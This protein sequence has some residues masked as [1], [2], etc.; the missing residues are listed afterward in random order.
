MAGKLSVYTSNFVL[1]KILR[2]TDWTPPSS[3]WV[4]L[5]LAGSETALRNNTVT[6]G[7]E[8]PNSNAYARQEIRGA[9]SIT[10]PA[11]TAGS[12]SNSA[13]IVFPTATGS[14]G[15][16]YYVALLDSSTI[17]AGNVILY[18][19]LSTAKPVDSGDTM[20]INT[21]SMVLSL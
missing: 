21:G 11:S 10:F 16:I 9:T 13:A 4:G 7:I 6:S 15:T 5:F 12:T 1:N 20:R 17:G 14:W 2:S 3:Y 8:V 19:S 18:G